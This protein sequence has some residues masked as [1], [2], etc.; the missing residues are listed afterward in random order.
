M[1]RSP[2]IWDSRIPK[3]GTRN[4]KFGTPESQILDPNDTDYN[5]TDYIKTESNDTDDLNDKKLTYPNNHTNHSNHDNSNFNN[6]AL[7]FQL[8][9]ELPQSIQNYLSNFEVTE[10]KLLKLYY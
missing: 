9:E 10:I 4:S 8:L 1:T 6:E 3:F 7:K 2:K 5:D